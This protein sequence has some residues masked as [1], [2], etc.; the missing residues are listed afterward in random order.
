VIFALKATNTFKAII[1]LFEHL[2]FS[3]WIWVADRLRWSAWLGS[4]FMVCDTEIHGY[5]VQ[6]CT[7]W[8]A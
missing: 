6:I 3:N 2:L 1:E 4:P 8:Q 7:S 5:Q